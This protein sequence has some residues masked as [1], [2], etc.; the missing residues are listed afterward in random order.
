MKVNYPSVEFDDLIAAHCHGQISDQQM[1]ALYQ[2]LSE[3]PAA[4]DEYILRLEIH[5]QLA[6][7]IDLFSTI[8]Q[9]NEA[10]VFAD[11]GK[12]KW[13]QWNV[14]NIGIAACFLLFAI[15]FGTWNVL[16]NQKM[17]APTSRAVAMLEEAIDVKWEGRSPR[18]GDPIEPGWLNLETG[19]VQIAFY[20]G[21][22]VVIEGPAEL[23]LV[24]VNRAVF[25]RG[26]I[27]ANV[28]MQARGFQ[29]E[30][31]QGEITDLGT[32]FGLDVTDGQTELHVF[33]GEVK[34]KTE[35]VLG[36]SFF[37]G[38]G[39]VF[40]QS[41]SSR[42]I[43]AS[44]ES[45]G[46]LFGIEERSKAASVQRLHTWRDSGQML[47][48]DPTLLT[49]FAFDDRF[50]TK[51]KLNNSSQMKLFTG[52]ATIVGC[53]W[54]QGRWPGKEALEFQNV[55]DRVRMTIPG[56][57]EK[58]TISMWVQVQGL[59][60]ELNSLFMCDGFELGSIHWLIRN[61][62]VMGMTVVGKK[63]GE[64]QIA[65]SP[66]VM[67][68]DKFG[69]WTHLA[70]VVDGEKGLVR[71][72]VNGK[73]VGENKLHMTPPFRIG[74]AE[75][76]NWNAKDFPGD[77]PF[78]IRNFSGAVDEFC[79]FSRGLSGVDIYKLYLQGSP[80]PSASQSHLSSTDKQ[81]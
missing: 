33:E 49:R 66:P 15:G 78:M 65:M 46:S 52:D 54:A 25:K 77:D 48:N 4:R 68:L 50:S 34:L 31:P 71:H 59:D 56:E 3:N 79:L 47:N 81:S 28:P 1:D 80:D 41:G 29:I 27:T 2:L 64:F 35:S 9:S 58:L 8:E 67:T 23:K 37:E 57:Y 73:V 32:A 39:V 75:I 30:T 61:D 24:S 45:F 38:N 7:D 69:R 72:Y 26:K 62:G 14:W 36:D 11:S 19:L 40:E 22:R 5:S 55:N 43:Q 74:T 17:E 20:N 76:G 53:S 51:W 21:A 60:R 42:S 12:S 70:V 13:Y 44:R 63:P 16:L 10:N 6:S 18:L